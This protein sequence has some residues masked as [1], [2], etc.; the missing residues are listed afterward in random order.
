M[1]CGVVFRGGGRFQFS[2]GL[3]KSISKPNSEAV[4]AA[5]AAGGGGARAFDFIVSNPPYIPAPDMD[6]LQVILLVTRSCS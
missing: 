4:L 2:L 3:T 1:G 6:G 5:A